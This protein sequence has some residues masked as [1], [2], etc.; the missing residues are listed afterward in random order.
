MSSNDVYTEPVVDYTKGLRVDGK[1]FLVIGAGQGMG[2]QTTL[3]LAQ[4]G[5]KVSCVDLDPARAEAVAKEV[6]GTPISGDATTEAGVVAIL[7]QAV[8]ANGPLDG[9]ADIIGMAHF[10]PIQ[11]T[12]EEIFVRQMMMNLG[13]A[14]LLLGKLPE[15]VNPKGASVAFVASVSGLRSS[16]LHAAY[17]AAKAGLINLVGSA[18]VE[19]GPRIR[20]NAV[21]P[22]QTRTPR[23]TE[24]HKGDDAYWAA[25][26]KV[27]AGRMGETSD[28]AGALLYFLSDLSGWV[29][30]QTLVLDGG[31]GRKYQYTFR[32][33]PGLP[34]ES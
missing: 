14:Y 23:M 27:P 34:K 16:P 12:N 7:Q 32:G 8:A 25:T 26:T 33:E 20:I 31:A 22:G 17:G 6:D 19:L 29:T 1:H 9:V 21:A 30:G 5:A 4:N 15:Y 24:A 28:I 13:H 11:E 2:R 3:A 10:A 18:A